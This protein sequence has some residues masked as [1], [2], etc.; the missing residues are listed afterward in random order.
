MMI[1]PP[2]EPCK[3]A[4]DRMADGGGGPGGDFEGGVRR[5]DR[6]EGAAIIDG[7]DEIVVN[8]G[9]RVGM[10]MRTVIEQVTHISDGALIR[11]PCVA[12]TR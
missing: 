8:E 4:G 10:V 6:R 11:L 2:K 5:G 7:G 9:Q 1:S 12:N 3:R